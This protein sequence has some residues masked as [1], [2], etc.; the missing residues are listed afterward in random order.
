MGKINLLVEFDNLKKNLMNYTDIIENIK[1]LKAI[2]SNNVKYSFFHISIKMF[3]FSLKIENLLKGYRIC[4][5][6]FPDTQINNLN[7]MIRI[8]KQFLTGVFGVNVV[9]P[10]EKKMQLLK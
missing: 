10:S 6:C 1:F 9:S 7:N 4:S 5:Y 3:Q 2:Y 8:S